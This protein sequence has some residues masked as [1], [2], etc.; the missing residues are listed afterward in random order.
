MLFVCSK[1]IQRGIVKIIHQNISTKNTFSVYHNCFN[2][3]TLEERHH[4]VLMRC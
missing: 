2:A 4:C 1:L 3:Q